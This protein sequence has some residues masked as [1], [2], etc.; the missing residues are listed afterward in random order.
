VKQNWKTATCLLVAMILTTLLVIKGQK[1]AK[2]EDHPDISQFP[3]VD[4]SARKVR[5]EKEQKRSKKYNSGAPVIT[6]ETEKLISYS[7]WDLKLP[8]L[9]VKISTA[10]IIGEV[11]DAQAY[12]S[13]DQTRIYSEFVVQIEQVLKNDSKTTPLNVGTSVITERSGG[14]VRFPSGKIAVSVINNQDLPR[15]GR[16]YLL[17]LTHEG[18]EAKLYDDFHILT[19][20]ELRDGKVFPLDKPG[21]THPMTAYKGANETSLFNDLAMVLAH[22]P[23]CQARNRSLPADPSSRAALANHARPMPNAWYCCGS[24]PILIDVDGNGFALTDAERGVLFDFNGDGI[25]GQI[26]WTAAGVDDA[27]LVLDRNGNGTIDSGTELFGNVTPQLAPPA[28][29]EKNGFL[30]LV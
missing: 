17:F 16:R 11:S 7:D 10:V 9:P 28:G 23:D 18:P 25:K 2:N 8:A 15:S 29:E 14:R 27:W 1:Q 4:Y 6:E 5:T 12:L 26:S 13:D 22:D 3:T 30:A 19:A 21:S 24:S 20:Y